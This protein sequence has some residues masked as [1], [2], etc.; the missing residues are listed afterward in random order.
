MLQNDLFAMC[1]SGDGTC[2]S[3][4]DFISS[5]ENEDDYITTSNIANNLYFLYQKT[6]DESYSYEIKN[7][8]HNFFKTAFAKIGWDAK[9]N[10]PH[11]NALL[12]SYLIGV[13][14]KLDDDEVIAEANKRFEQYLKNPSSLNP[15]IQEAVFSTAAWGGDDKTYQKL[16]NLYRKDK[17]Q[18]EKLRSLVALCN[19]K[20]EKL[21][22]KTLEF[23]QS[24]EVRSQNMHTPIM[25]VA[26][27]PHGRRILWPWIKKN[28]KSLRTKVGIGSPLLNRIVASLSGFADAQVGKEIEQF[29]EKNPTPGTERTIEQ[30]LERIRI[31]AAMLERFRQEF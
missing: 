17:T 20:D 13:L 5:Y 12:R 26:A 22:L 18:E 9:E 21:L 24:R 10:E 29:F 16:V 4:L 31:H 8:A 28:W 14:G 19:F 2:R 11:T 15:D 1:I 30:T 27:N 7:M 3:Y 25:R 23:S 6:R